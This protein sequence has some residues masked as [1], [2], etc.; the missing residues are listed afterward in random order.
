MDAGAAALKVDCTGVSTASDVAV[1]MVSLL[2]YVDGEERTLGVLVLGRFG[3]AT[4]TTREKLTRGAPV[5]VTRGAGPCATDYHAT[6]NTSGVAQVPR[7]ATGNKLAVA[8][9]CTLRHG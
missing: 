6:G 3:F 9:L 8:H 1:V 7:C 5:L 2:G 4:P